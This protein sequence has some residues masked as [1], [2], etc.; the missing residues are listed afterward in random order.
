MIFTER[1]GDEDFSDILGKIL[2]FAALFRHHCIRV[3]YLRR[4]GMDFHIQRHDIL[5][6][7][8]IK[9]EER[10]FNITNAP[11][12]HRIMNMAI[13]P[14][15]EKIIFDLTGVDEIDSV[16]I[17][18]LAFTRVMASRRGIDMAIACTDGVRKVLEIL[19]MRSTFAAYS[20]VEDAIKGS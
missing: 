18:I 10:S 7:S 15:T 20:N 1:T 13:K 5:N 17:G 12:V 14:G 19:N 2:L 6:A 3:I 4:A 11:S 8:V 9:V 16:G